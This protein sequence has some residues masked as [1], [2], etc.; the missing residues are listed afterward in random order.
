MSACVLTC[1]SCLIGCKSPFYYKTQADAEV[2]NIIDNKWQDNFGSKANYRLNDSESFP[3]A[4]EIEKFVPQSGVLSLPQA[5]ALATKYNRQY[6]LEKEL[7]YISA[8]DLMLV[9]HQYEPQFFGSARGGYAK[10]TGE[11]IS[12]LETGFESERLVQELIERRVDPEDLLNRPTGTG[13]GFNQ[14]LYTGALFSTEVAV[15][16]WRIIG[17]DLP[18]DSL[19]SVLRMNVVQPLLRGSDRAVVME[20]LTQAERDTL[21]QLRTF[22][23]FR[24]TFVVSIINQYHTILLQHDFVNNARLNYQALAELYEKTEKLVKAGRIPIEELD[25]IRQEK[26]NAWDNIIQSEKIYKQLLDEFKISMALPANLEFQL[27]DNELDVLRKAGVNKFQFS[28]DEAINTALALRLD[29][30]NKADFIIDAYRKIAVAADSFRPGLNINT[31]VGVPIQSITSDSKIFADNLET[32]L[33]LDLPLD[34]E[35][36]QNLYGKALITFNMRR[37]EYEEARDLIM[38]QV[39][40]DYRDLIE[41]Y[42]RYIVQLESIELAQKRLDDTIVLLQYGR[43]SSRRVLDAQQ[44]LFDAQNAASEALINYTNATLNFYCNTGVLQVRPDG[45]WQTTLIVDKIPL[46]PNLLLLDRLS[47]LQ[48]EKKQFDTSEPNRIRITQTKSDY[49]NQLEI[50]MIMKRIRDSLSESQK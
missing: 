11:D 24:Q 31:K 43:A 13:I 32:F 44:N 34:R 19:S 17:G 28:E 30:A 33:E 35:L 46:F 1:I 41:A 38:L 4:N 42:E 40:Q 23:R 49:D 29:L 22:N 7:L 45:M 20:N 16:W 48:T 9:R 14:L 37:R 26:L 5:V 25:R 2:Y 27:D 47:A 8:L 10:A 50:I 12:T 18:G 36:E 6:Q 21:Y 15:G 3:E 39:R